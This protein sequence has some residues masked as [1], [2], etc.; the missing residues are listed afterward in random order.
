VEEIADGEHE[1]QAARPRTLARRER[2]ARGRPAT[3]P[4][5]NRKP[6]AVEPWNITSNWYQGAARSA[7]DTR[8]S[9]M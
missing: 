4:E 7:A 2:G 6:G 5:A 9:K 8:S 3:K 1:E